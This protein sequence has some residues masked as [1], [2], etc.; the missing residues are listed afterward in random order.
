MSL[1]PSSATPWPIADGGQGR[2]SCAPRRL[3][4][5]TCSLI[6][7]GQSFAPNGSRGREYWLELSI[8]VRERLMELLAPLGWQHEFEPFEAE[9]YGT[10]SWVGQGCGHL[11]TF[12]GVA[13]V[14]EIV[15]VHF[16]PPA[17]RSESEPPLGIRGQI[18]KGRA[19]GCVNT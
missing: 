19:S 15:S 13:R 4:K 12:G 2:M 16:T 7:E 3:L 11:G 5:G 10:L 14:Q 9:F 18:K 8:E 1:P 17:P 6:F